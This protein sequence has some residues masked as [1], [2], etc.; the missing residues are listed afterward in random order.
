[1]FKGIASASIDAKGRMPLP[2]LYRE[3][4]LG[5]AGGK[6]VVT[7]DVVEKCLVLYTLPEWEVVQRR[8]EKLPNVG[9]KGRLLQRLL[10]G[11]AVELTLDGNG[12]I[13]LPQI[14]RDHAD[15]GK[16]VMTVGQGNKI[17]L[18]SEDVWNAGMDDWLSAAGRQELGD[19]D[20]FESLQ[21]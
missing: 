13:L 5:R 20:E 19:S 16:K 8:L 3:E 15:L 18:W 14:H 2:T 6:V 10:I 17:E 11:H 1:M 9:R 12:R 21:I 7:I 4:V